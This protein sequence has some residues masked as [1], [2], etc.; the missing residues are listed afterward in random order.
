MDSVKTAILASDVLRSDFNGCVSL[1]KDFMS[2]NEGVSAG[3]FNL[4]GLRSGQG[5]GTGKRTGRGRG[6]GKEAQ[7]N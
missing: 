2:Q 5:K 7:S 4:S 6:G 1:Y 3:D